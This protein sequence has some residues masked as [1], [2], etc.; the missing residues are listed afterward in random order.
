M[1]PHG[2]RVERDRARRVP[3][4]YNPARTV[5]A[6]IDDQP[7]TLV[8]ERAWVASSSSVDSR[9]PTRTQVIT[10][11]SLYLEDPDADVQ[12]GDRVRWGG[13][14]GWVRV[15]PEADVNPFTG[16]QP[17]LE[18]PLEIVEG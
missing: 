13:S 14:A 1:F 10:A 4:P 15:R 18:I 8:V 9:D 2:Q 5:P 7:D 17:V 6:D 12:V 16:W 3:D 11:K